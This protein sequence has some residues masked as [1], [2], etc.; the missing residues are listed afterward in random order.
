MGRPACCGRGRIHHLPWS[1]FGK[2]AQT[3]RNIH[4]PHHL[5]ERQ[6][7]WRPPSSLVPKRAA[8]A[9]S[10]PLVGRVLR[11]SSFQAGSSQQST[12]FGMTSGSLA[13]SRSSSTTSNLWTL[14]HMGMQ[15]QNGLSS[16]VNSVS[17]MRLS[18]WWQG[19]I[20]LRRG[21]GW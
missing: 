15:T 6:S 2:L 8:A 10:H 1:T 16:I 11:C 9:C 4:R 14:L 3:C 5:C 17:S 21:T 19:A 13:L 20:S 18:P 7:L 12:A